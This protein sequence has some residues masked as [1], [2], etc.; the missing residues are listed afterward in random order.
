MRVLLL[1]LAILGAADTPASYRA[2][3][4][5]HRRERLAELT[6]PNGW[7][8]V[9][10]LFWLHEGENTAG[11]DPTS[12]IRLPARAPKRL[13]VFTLKERVV[14]FTA[15]PSATVTAAGKS[16]ETYTFEGR[17]GERSAIS[18]AGLSLFVLRRSDR[19]GL[20]LLDPESVP[21][22]TF[23]G[24]Q[25]FPLDPAF[26]L[27]AKFVAYPALKEVPVPNVLGQLVPMQSPGYVEF[28]LKGRTY[29]L[30]PVYETAARSDLFFIFKDQTSRGGQ[31][32]EAGRFLH[33]PLPVD[34]V[35]DLD[36]NRAYN[37]P[38]AFTEF[39]TCP[40]P[41]KANHLPVAIRAGELNYHL[42]K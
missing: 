22:K 8:A 34:G 41:V 4:E 29:R 35:V 27:K 3:I 2:E 1:L 23:P 28:V 10:G 30:E 20:R 42:P 38:C 13:G 15:D 36:F 32:Y 26:R 5:K 6:A 31:T 39:A 19:I 12:E 21:R 40:L 24:L 37:P 9:R 14:S 17:G 18:A 16:I 7:L 33:T 11:S 25:Y